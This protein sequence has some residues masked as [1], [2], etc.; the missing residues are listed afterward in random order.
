MAKAHRGAGILDLENRGRG[1]CPLCK[2]TGIKVMY[3]REANEKKVMVCK[4]CEA[5]LKHGKM[6]DALKA[7]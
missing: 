1:T 6:Q 3:E 4:Q 7:L 5:A 2:R